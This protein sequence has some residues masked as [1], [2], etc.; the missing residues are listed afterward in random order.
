MRPLLVRL[1]LAVVPIGLLCGCSKA[2]NEQ[3]IRVA[4]IGGM[5]TTGLWQEITKRFEAATHH[6]I[7]LVA[8]GQREIV[9]AA[10]REGKIDLATMHSGDIT[11]DLVADGFGINLRPWTRNDLVIVGPK[12]DPAGVRGLTSGATALRRIAETKSRYVDFAGIGSRELAHNLWKAAGISPQ[13]DWVIADRSR[14]NTDS[15]RFASQNQAYIIVG[16][17]PVLS[18]KVQGDDMEILVQGDPAMRRSF[19]VME[20][21]AKK[22]PGANSEGARALSDYLVSETTQRFL[23]TFGR[24]NAGG[25]PLFHPIAEEA[26]NQ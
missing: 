16:R 23:E 12:E 14:G 2:P 24:D 5:T 18:G 6:K 1:A 8:T 4:V 11:T 17:I 13:G 10:L 22:F 9:A 7:D 15:L 20:A 19:V 3:P 26:R 25:I 21:N